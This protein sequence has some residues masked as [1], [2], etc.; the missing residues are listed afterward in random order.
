MILFDSFYKEF[1]DTV[2]KERGRSF[3]KSEIVI[4]AFSA[5]FLLTAIV[6]YVIKHDFN[7]NI[8]N[9]MVYDAT[10]FASFILF[11]V[12]YFVLLTVMYKYNKKTNFEQENDEAIIKKCKALLIKEKY[13]SKDK[14]EWLLSCCEKRLIYYS[15][16]KI[17]SVI[18]VAIKMVLPFFTLFVGVVLERSSNEELIFLLASFSI[19][20]V[21]LILCGVGIVSITDSISLSKNNCIRLLIQCLEYL[22]TDIE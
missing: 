11:V 22:K 10:T 14:I 15:S 2:Y 7:V 6:M 5:V 1:K 21:I 16:N 8:S 4:L 9:P 17:S 18:N 13:N 12:F 3:R 20:L 19:L